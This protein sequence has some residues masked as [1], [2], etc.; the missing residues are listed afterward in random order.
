[1]CQDRFPE[2][3]WDTDMPHSREHATDLVVDL[4]EAANCLESL[5]P[6]EISELMRD[7]AGVLCELVNPYCPTEARAAGCQRLPGNVVPIDR[8]TR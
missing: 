3:P 1:M 7:A 4:L 5:T 8:C 6:N 2:S